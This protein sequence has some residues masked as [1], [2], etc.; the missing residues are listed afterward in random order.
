MLGALLTSGQDLFLGLERGRTAQRE[1]VKALAPMEDL[2]TLDCM[3][4]V[5]CSRSWLGGAQR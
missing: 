4:D 1:A 2:W 5:F 3:G